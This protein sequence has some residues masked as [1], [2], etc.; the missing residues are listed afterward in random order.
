M[1]TEDRFKAREGSSILLTGCQ[2]SLHMPATLTQ[3]L[4]DSRDRK[5]NGK[6]QLHLPYWLRTLRSLPAGF[7]S[8]SGDEAQVRFFKCALDC[9]MR[10]ARS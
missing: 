8:T 3:F 7:S 10:N 6:H 9:H 2:D 5:A 4:A 1:P